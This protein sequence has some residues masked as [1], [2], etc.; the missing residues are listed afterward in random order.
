MIVEFGRSFGWSKRQILDEVYPDEALVLLQ[1]LS[2]KRAEDQ[3]RDLEVSF[4]G[5]ASS[6]Y[7]LNLVNRL[8]SEAHAGSVV[9]D[10]HLD[11]EGVRGLKLLLGGRGV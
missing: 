4:A 11:R 9:R 3:L 8:R 1:R 2:R 5:S 7:R 6:E 10:D